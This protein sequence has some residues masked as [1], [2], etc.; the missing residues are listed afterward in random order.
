MQ[1]IFHIQDSQDNSSTIKYLC[2]FPFRTMSY[3]LKFVWFHDYFWLQEYR[4]WQWKSS[5]HVPLHCL[6]KCSTLTLWNI[7]FFDRNIRRSD[8]TLE[9]VPLFWQRNCNPTHPLGTFTILYKHFGS[10][11]HPNLASLGPF[12]AHTLISALIFSFDLVAVST[13][14]HPCLF[15]VCCPC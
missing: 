10:I 11:I 1:N 8:T 15:S 4:P 13:L 2:K 6:G 3:N 5:E 14:S 9:N 7:F 12:L